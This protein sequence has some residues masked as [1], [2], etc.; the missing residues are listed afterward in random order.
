MT[1][2]KTYQSTLSGKKTVLQTFNKSRGPLVLLSHALLWDAQI[3]QYIGINFK[4]YLRLRD[5]RGCVSVA[6]FIR[7]A[8][9]SLQNDVSREHVTGPSATA[10]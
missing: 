9:F 5:G 4:M 10:V 6:R 3:H 2:H 8:S 7:M 1:S